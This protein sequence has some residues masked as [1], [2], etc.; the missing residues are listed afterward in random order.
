MT[1]LEGIRGPTRADSDALAGLTWLHREA[2]SL[3]LAQGPQRARRG[4][5]SIC[6]G[7]G[8]DGSLGGRKGAASI[9]T[10]GEPPPDV[11][12]APEDAMQGDPVYGCVLAGLPPELQPTLEALL[13]MYPALL[14]EAADLEAAKS[15]AE[16]RVQQLELEAGWP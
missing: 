2:P 7:Y 3:A 8:Q 10:V 13:G 12:R 1:S 16:L 4:C 14:V 6:S 11:W 15:D 5:C 9:T